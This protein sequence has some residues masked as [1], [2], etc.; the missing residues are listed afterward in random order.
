MHLSPSLG[1]SFYDFFMD[2]AGIDRRPRNKPHGW[3]SVVLWRVVCCRSS[4]SL[5]QEPRD[6]TDPPFPVVR[7]YAL[8]PKA[9]D[10]LPE[11]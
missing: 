4:L 5:I 1:A 6:A 10:K 9:I 11:P 3:R 8:D 2:T 7:T